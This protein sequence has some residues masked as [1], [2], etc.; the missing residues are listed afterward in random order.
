MAEF[1]S[2]LVQERGQRLKEIRKKVGYRSTRAFSEQ[3]PEFAHG[4]LKN[5][6]SAKSNAGLTSRGATRLSKAF[7]EDGWNVSTAWLLYGDE[8]TPSK[9]EDEIPPS[10]KTL[11]LESITEI[12]VAKRNNI[13]ISEINKFLKEYESG[14][15][16][17]II[18]NNLSP[19]LQL[20][21]YVCG[22]WLMPE[23]IHLL[24]ERYCIC[25]TER[26]ET[27][28]GVLIKKEKLALYDSSGQLITDRIN[29]VA[30]IT[31][32]YPGKNRILNL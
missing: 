12:L 22:V 8:P 1:D 4:T 17:Q 10:P 5:W 30:A 29:R 28:C 14:V 2:E 15:W 9:I 25:E 23:N 24:H 26:L 20:G 7:N 19:T 32:I 11:G 31:I 13:I 27:V 3:H 21:D 18:A 6:E 16:T